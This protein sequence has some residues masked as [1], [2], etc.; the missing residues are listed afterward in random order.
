MAL[1]MLLCREGGEAVLEVLA[2]RRDFAAGHKKRAE[3]E[4]VDEDAIAVTS[5]AAQ[6]LVARRAACAQLVADHA[7]HHERV[8]IAPL[9]E[10]RVNVHE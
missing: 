3:V 10:Q 5:G 6:V 1:C 2:K 7:L 8:L 9:V 4:E